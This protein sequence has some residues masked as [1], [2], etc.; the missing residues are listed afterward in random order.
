[1]LG[2]DGCTW[3]HRGAL[4]VP[5]SGGV[6][7]AS[8]ELV[9]DNGWN[10]A[11]LLS[12]LAAAPGMSAEG[13]GSLAVTTYRNYYTHNQPLTSVTL[14]A[15]RSSD[16]DAIAVEIDSVARQLQ[17]GLANPVTAAATVAAIT[18]ARADVQEIDPIV[19]QF[20]YVDLV[21]LFKRLGVTTSL[22]ALVKAATIAEYH[23]SRDPER[24]GFPLYLRSPRCENL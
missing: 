22:P 14:V 13:F 7:V 23:G 8:E 12:G 19:T 11:A 1:V 9:P 4:R 2:F 15:L 6:L 5:R 21:D 17:A 16:L 18:R 3:Y 10:Y 24:T 20:V